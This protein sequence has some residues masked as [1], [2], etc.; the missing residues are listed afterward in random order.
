MKWDDIKK[1]IDQAVEENRI[2]VVPD[3]MPIQPDDTIDGSELRG[4]RLVGEGT[5]LVIHPPR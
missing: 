5:T 1:Y 4:C 3:A 2:I